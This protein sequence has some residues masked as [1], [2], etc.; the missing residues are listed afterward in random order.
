MIN[1][2]KRKEQ[3]ITPGIYLKWVAVWPQAPRLSAVNEVKV[4]LFHAGF[5]PQ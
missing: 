1:E 4:Q 5:N 3:K 2:I